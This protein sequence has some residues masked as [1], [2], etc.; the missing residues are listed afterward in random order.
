MDE[1]ARLLLEKGSRAPAWEDEERGNYDLETLREEFRRR[2][3]G[4]QV[5]GSGARDGAP[6]GKYGRTGLTC[7]ADRAGTGGAIPTR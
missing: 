6:S 7:R 5:N 2:L 4:R 1:N 3:Y